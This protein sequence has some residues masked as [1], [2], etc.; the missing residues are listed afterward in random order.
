MN[1]FSNEVIRKWYH[2]MPLTRHQLTMTRFCTLIWET[3]H[4]QRL[5]FVDHSGAISVETRTRTC[6][7]RGQTR[8]TNS[9]LA[10]NL[11]LIGWE[12]GASFLDQSQSA[13]KQT[14]SELGLL[15]TLHTYFRH[16]R[17]LY[18]FLRTSQMIYRK[19]LSASIYDYSMVMLLTKWHGKSRLVE[20]VRLLVMALLHLISFPWLTEEI[21]LQETRGFNSAFAHW[22]LSV[23]D[24]EAPIERTYRKFSLEELITMLKFCSPKKLGESRH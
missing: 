21:T 18:I 2:S 6:L 5:K 22:I 23:S 17:L 3:F 4:A 1:L 7:K 24:V 9:R 11:D 12:D 19:V 16:R 15:L 13:V 10:F 20:F 8:L 14:Q